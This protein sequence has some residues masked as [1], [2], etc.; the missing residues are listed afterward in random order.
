MVWLDSTQNGIERGSCST[1]AGDPSTL[2]EQ[3]ADAKVSYTN[4]KWG[5]IGSTQSVYPPDPTPSPPTPSP[6]TPGP[7]TP[8]PPTPGPPTPSPPTPS[9]T[10]DDCPGGSLSACIDICPKDP[11]TVY[12][13]CVN[14]CLERCPSAETLV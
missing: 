7:P 6:P 3:Y 1:S 4:F 11:T 9:P 13:I 5:A 12:Q 2:R 8:G 14:T 10:P